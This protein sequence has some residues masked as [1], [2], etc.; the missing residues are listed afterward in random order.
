MPNLVDAFDSYKDFSR[1][2]YYTI[3]FNK[4]PSNLRF[5][6]PLKESK[7]SMESV[8][9]SFDFKG[10]QLQEVFKNWTTEDDK[11]SDSSN[12]YP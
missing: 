5:E 10:L 9:A 2:P 6:T 3:C 8:I 12:D 4:L 7:E 11:D 1:Y